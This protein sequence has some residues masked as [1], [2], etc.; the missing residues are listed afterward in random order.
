MKHRGALGPTIGVG[1][2]PPDGNYR[3]QI[4]PEYTHEP[5][6]GGLGIWKGPSTQTGKPFSV[7]DGNQNVSITHDFRLTGNNT[8]AGCAILIKAD[9]TNNRPFGMSD[10][11]TTDNDIYGYE[12]SGN[13]IKFRH[14]GGYN[15]MVFKQN[16]STIIGDQAQ[17]G[18][19]SQVTITSS[20]GRVG[21]Y[22]TTPV[23]KATVTGSRGGNAALASLLTALASCGL[24]TN[25]TT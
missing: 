19:A 18:V 2:T 6:M 22:G 3:F 13:D 10:N 21:F 24:I 16:G 8:F 1:V 9:A 20:G 23:A 5:E 7:Y 12:F 15:Y 11:Q 14:F 25:S 4:A 17:S